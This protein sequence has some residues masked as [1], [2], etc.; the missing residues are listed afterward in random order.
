MRKV[1]PKVKVPTFEKEEVVESLEKVETAFSEVEKEDE[2]D[3]EEL[4][5][6]QDTVV[7]SK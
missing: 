1:I 2:R 4:I 6:T 5:F 3:A 7:L